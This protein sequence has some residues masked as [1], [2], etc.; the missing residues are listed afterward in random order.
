MKDLSEHIL[1]ILHKEQVC[2]EWIQSN[3]KEKP[4]VILGGSGCGKSQLAKYLLKDFTTIVINSENCRNTPNLTD[5]LNDSLYK[6]SITM[7]FRKQRPYKSLI[8]DDLDYI[9]L[10]D[11][12]LFKSII[13]FSK[14]SHRQHPIIYIVSSLD[15]KDIKYLYNHCYPICIQFTEKQLYVIVRDYFRNN[16]KHC[17]PTFIKQLIDKCHSNF[18][19]IQSNLSFHKKKECIQSYEKKETD[20]IKYYNHLVNECSLQDLFRVTSCN[21]TIISLN[22]LQNYSRS[23]DESQ[24]LSDKEKITILDK[25]YHSIC[26]GDYYGQLYLSNYSSGLDESQILLDIGIPVIYLRKY[27]PMIHSFTYTKIISKCIIYTHHL[28]L[29]KQVSLDYEDLFIL[30]YMLYKQY[31][32]KQINNYI[33]RL[34][35]TQKMFYKFIKYY[36]S[37]YSCKIMKQQVK[38]LVF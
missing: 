5:Y 4:L 17:K 21:Y 16:E 34:G 38:Q 36:E 9:R 33:H 23:I 25:I 12:S 20:H 6:K 15:N 8:F 10:N 14:E 11:K 3:Y 2:E 1:H 30:F 37:M 32:Y 7:L 24:N 19:S 26:L 35:I 28:K 31:D 13:Q 22:I 29:L 27:K 18:H